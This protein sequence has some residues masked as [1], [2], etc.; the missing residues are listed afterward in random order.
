M[1]RIRTCE[2]LASAAARKYSSATQQ[3]IT[4]Y[5]NPY[6]T[7]T[8]TARPRPSLSPEIKGSSTP[9]RIHGEPIGVAG[10]ELVAFLGVGQA[11]VGT[12]VV[13]VVQAA[14]VGVH[15][16]HIGALEFGDCSQQGV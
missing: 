7:A 14:Q 10:F 12:A 6:L 5:A 2:V 3:L 16:D 8:T 15:G 4:S 13:R 11:D 1:E 9:K